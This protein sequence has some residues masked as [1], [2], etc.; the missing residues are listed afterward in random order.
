MNGPPLY[1][2]VFSIEEKMNFFGK[3]RIPFLFVISYDKN[4]GTVLPLTEIPPGIFY[5]VNGIKNFQEKKKVSGGSTGSRNP[6]SFHTYRAA[7][8]S[9]IDEIVKGNSYVA[10]LTFPTEIHPD[11]SLKNIFMKARAPFRLF[12]LDQFVTF[13][14]ER[15]V[16]ISGTRIETFPMKGTID[17]SLP[18]A[19]ETII[20]NEKE[21]AEHVMI[22]DLLR[23]DL[24][25]VARKVQVDRFRY[26]D[27]ITTSTGP[28]LQVSSQISGSL[29]TDWHR[30]IG[31]LMMN[32]LPAGSITGAPKKS[33][34]EI[35][36]RIEP[37]NRGFYTGVFGV[38]TGTELD[39]AVMIRFIEKEKETSRF[40]SGGGITIDSR[41]EDEYRE[42]L[43]KVYLPF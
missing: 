22:V 20:N 23:N 24:S 4:E 37:D 27:Q 18:G 16:S 17:A 13:S 36:Q 19:D 10:N 8:D 7:F 40:R 1:S 25:M 32:I 38:F 12:Y 29:D 11:I 33:T 30:S 5:D 14:P 34:V 21:M 26:I 41:P 43:Q 3:N 9:V 35:L 39:S 28:L 2:S 31:T 15:F 42:L 6:V